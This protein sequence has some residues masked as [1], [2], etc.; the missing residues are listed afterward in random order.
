[1]TPANSAKITSA[2]TTLSSSSSSSPEKMSEIPFVAISQAGPKDWM[3]WYRLY[4]VAKVFQPATPMES[5]D[6]SRDACIQD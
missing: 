6:F 5:R 4:A 2:S 1:M 3:A